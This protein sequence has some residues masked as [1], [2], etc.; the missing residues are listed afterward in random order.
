MV[1]MRESNHG[2]EAG[3]ADRGCDARWS[4]AWTGKRR[5]SR[6]KRVGKSLTPLKIVARGGRFEEGGMFQQ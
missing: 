1:R 5:D 4:I 3:T 6:T 2:R